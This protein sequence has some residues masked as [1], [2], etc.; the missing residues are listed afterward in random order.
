MAEKIKLR[1]K[2]IHL[3]FG[4]LT[5]L[6]GVSFDVRESELLAIIGPNGA[7]AFPPPACG[8]PSHRG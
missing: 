1:I 2:D 7:G 5:A 6:A 8:T 4:G 3:S